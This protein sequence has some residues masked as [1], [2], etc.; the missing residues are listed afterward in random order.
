MRH[1]LDWLVRAIVDTGMSRKA[2]QA[3]HGASAWGLST[4]HAD[5]QADGEVAIQRA[6]LGCPNSA[7]PIE[8]MKRPSN[9][10]G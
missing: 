2:A 9:G 8:P 4:T 5:P 10:E 3:P 6:G 7:E 1:A